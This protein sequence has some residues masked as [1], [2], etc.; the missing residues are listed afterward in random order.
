MTILSDPLVSFV[1]TIIPSVIFIDIGVTNVAK[2]AHATFMKSFGIA[3]IGSILY[4]I[5]GIIM[6]Y[7]TSA[8]IVSWLLVE[9]AVMGIIK[10]VYSTTWGTAFRAWIIY[11]IALLVLCLVLTL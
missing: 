6:R 2:I 5:V 10:A 4:M 9:V 7:H 8:F 3:L 1:F 11:F